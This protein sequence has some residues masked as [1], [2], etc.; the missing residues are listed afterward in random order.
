MV[1][2]AKCIDKYRNNNGVIFGYLLVDTQGNKIQIEADELKRQIR[3]YTLQVVNLTLTSDNRLIDK[4]ESKIVEV[5]PVNTIALVKES[6]VNDLMYLVNKN[7]KQDT[8]DP[9]LNRVNWDKEDTAK[10][11][12]ILR[13]LGIEVYRLNNSVIPRDGKTLY[14]LCCG[15]YLISFNNRGI[16]ILRY[17]K[18]CDE[19]YI[20]RK[21]ITEEVLESL[22]KETK[23][24]VKNF[25]ILLD[26]LCSQINDMA[27]RAKIKKLQI[28]SCSEDTVFNTVAFYYDANGKACELTTIKISETTKPGIMGDIIDYKITYINELDEC[29]YVDSDE[30]YNTDN[31]NLLEKGFVRTMSEKRSLLK[32]EKKMMT[33]LILA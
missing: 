24:D 25:G 33:F 5:K 31:S 6:S 28:R 2:R 10:A 17:D 32:K 22:I 20:N 9:H 14:K 26:K 21:E 11:L 4:E 15:R 12:I 19:L 30:L 16:S 3:N 29:E 7:R 13:S 1:I 23:N 18:S 27:K 8:R